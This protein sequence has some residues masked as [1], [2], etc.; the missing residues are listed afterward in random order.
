MLSNEKGI[1]LIEL[2]IVIAILSLVTAMA[3]SLLLTGVRSNA[4][5]SEGTNN[6]TAV[7]MA[8]SYIGREIRRA[9][10]V[11]QVGADYIRIKNNTDSDNNTL[12]KHEGNKI[13]MSSTTGANREFDGIGAF[14]LS[15]IEDDEGFITSVTMNI[16][17]TNTSRS[18]V[19]EKETTITIRK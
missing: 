9:K 13:I 11:D 4:R 8:S 19:A 17:S 18:K 14:Q 3:S 1:T 7:R 5:I 15:Y 12:F 16:K 2:I 6:E 10:N